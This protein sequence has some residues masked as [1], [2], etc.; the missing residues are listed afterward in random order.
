MAAGQ[1]KKEERGVMEGERPVSL[2]EPFSLFKSGER[3]VKILSNGHELISEKDH[4][5]ERWEVKG[6]GQINRFHWDNDSETDDSE[7]DDEPF[8]YGKLPSSLYDEFRESERDPKTSMCVNMNKVLETFK[9]NDIGGNLTNL[10]SLIDEVITKEEEIE[11]LKNKT[12]NLLFQRLNDCIQ[13]NSSDK[14]IHGHFCHLLDFFQE[15]DYCKKF[16]GQIQETAKN[17]IDV[18]KKHDKTKTKILSYQ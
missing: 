16:N 13:D 10:R 3:P 11:D 5:I 12:A 7:T 8:E 14:G 18:H 9:I 4:F 2:N 6:L 15:F 17:L 1:L